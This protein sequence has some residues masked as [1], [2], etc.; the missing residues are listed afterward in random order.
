MTT[1]LVVH[2]S[3]NYMEPMNGLLRPPKRFI[4]LQEGANYDNVPR[5]SSVAKLS[6]TNERSSPS[7]KKVH[8]L[9]RGR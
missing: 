2:R 4:I 8:N 6:G 7:P 9:T 5:R 3:P 1:F